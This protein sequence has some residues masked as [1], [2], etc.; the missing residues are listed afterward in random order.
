MVERINDILKRPLI[1]RLAPWLIVTIAAIL[2]LWN[3]GYPQKLV[4]DETYYVKD[5]WTLW[6]TGAER[7]WP[8]D[9]NA[10]LEAGN[11]S[12][13]LADP[14]FVV[15]PPLG[16]WIIGLGMW[17]FGP[18]NAF[19][20]RISVAV[21]GI[22]SVALIMVIALRLFKSKS[23]ALVAGFLFAIDGHAIV[24][25]RTALL[26]GIL[27][28]FVL[29]AFYFLLKDQRSRVLENHSWN[30]P[31]L[32]AAG[33]TLG[34]ATAV[35][36]SG[37]YFIAAFGIYVVVSEVLARKAAGDRYWIVDGIA[38]Q[39]FI[40]FLYLVPTAALVY[41]MSWVGWIISPTGYDR[42][43]SSNW[44]ESLIKYHQDAYAF[45]VGLRTPHSYASNP[46]TWIFEIRPTSF[47]YDSLKEGMGGCTSVGGC[48]SAIT[49][50]GNPLIWWPA[51]IALFF[52]A[53]WYFRTRE[54]VPGLILLGIAAGWL[55]WIA[56]M[57]RTVFQFYSIVFLP[58]SILALIFVIR[59]FVDRAKRPIMARGLV[60]GYLILAGLASAFFL[61]IWI[62]TWVPYGFWL[63]HMWLP[64][65]I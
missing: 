38:K 63:A 50:L 36:W 26:D 23:W 41:L 37:L 59:L 22:A 14:S 9:A 32:L 55:P 8:A 65:W 18:G 25:A 60:L 20:W 21:L 64:S 54:R 43:V 46:L 48:S 56:F 57:G 5:A 7:A 12:G 52:L 42:Q 4:F 30:R 45:H 28:F 35:K 49:A 15:H 1:D 3:L 61:P 39:G 47:F 11:A 62:G 53:A 34:A 10:A 17:L 24:L 6:N 13:Y 2:R 44:F 31:W 19:S 51:A 58:F 27:M 33:L 16:K 29:L 40:D